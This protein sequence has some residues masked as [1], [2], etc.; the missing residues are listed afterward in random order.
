MAHVCQNC[1]RSFDDRRY[2]IR[3]LCRLCRPKPEIK[4]IHETAMSNAQAKRYLDLA[5]KL[6]L[7]LPWDRDAIQ[8]EMDR[9]REAVTK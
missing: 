7:A 6:R 1:A 8:A 9:L 2:L 4:A 5:V 3:G